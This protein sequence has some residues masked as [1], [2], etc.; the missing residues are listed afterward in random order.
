MMLLNSRVS[1]TSQPVYKSSLRKMGMEKMRIKSSIRCLLSYR[2]TVCYLVRCIGS[3][4]LFVSR[5]RIRPPWL[6]LSIWVS[7]RDYGRG[8]Y[9]IRT[10]YSLTT[11]CWRDS[12]TRRNNPYLTQY[13]RNQP[14]RR[15]GLTRQHVYVRTLVVSM[16]RGGQGSG[17]R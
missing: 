3:V 6:F 4:I 12:K 10:S 1:S 7:H 16:L 13:L 5:I 11:R 8:V 17:S 2:T 14:T 9:C 15:R